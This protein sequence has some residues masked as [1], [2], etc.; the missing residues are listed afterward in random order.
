MDAFWNCKNVTVEN[1][2]IDGEYIGWNSE[3]LTFIN[4]TITSNQG[5]CYIKNLV[6][7]NCKLPATDLAFEYST[8]DA[9]ISSHIDSVKNPISGRIVA[10]S[11]G[12]II[13]ESER[14]DTG[15]TDI[16]TGGKN[17]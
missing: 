15:A 1:C 3:N 17:E 4:C 9:E 2:Y 10:D 11:I 12:E 13:H 16:I 7:R 8:V 14:V 6:M 5:L